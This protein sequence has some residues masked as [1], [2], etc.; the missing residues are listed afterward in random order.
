MIYATHGTV[1]R[2]ETFR[3]THRNMLDEA[4]YIHW[5][6]NLKEPLGSLDDAL[7]GKGD[8]L[9]IDDG[10]FAA[11]RAAELAVSLGHRVTLFVNPHHATTGA[12][13]FFA[14]LNAALDACTLRTVEWRGQ[15]CRLDGYGE[16]KEFR[17]RVK[18]EL[19]ALP[20]EALRETVMDEC[21]AC[22]ACPMAIGARPPRELESLNA[23]DLARLRDR[24]VEIENHGWTHGE[25]GALDAGAASEEIESARQWLEEFLDVRS[26]YFAVPFGDTFPPEGLAGGWRVWFLLTAGHP[27]G[28]LPERV[29]NR[30]TLE[31]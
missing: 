2:R 12:Q 29:Y 23:N 19:R 9:S 4:A 21:L 13:Y 8:A 14:R 24:G 31:L 3:F 11:A 15:R 17:A 30:Q 22:L 5:L 10:T 26:R 7:E 28:W 6:Q 1:A 18:K 16:K 27:V 25:L 20:S